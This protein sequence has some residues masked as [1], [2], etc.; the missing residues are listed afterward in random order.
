VFVDG[1]S[2]GDAPST[3]QRIQNQVQANDIHQLWGERTVRKLIIALLISA[4]FIVSGIS[5]TTFTSGQFTSSAFADGGDG[6]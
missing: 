6:G 4:A 2:R 1:N 5:A 3:W